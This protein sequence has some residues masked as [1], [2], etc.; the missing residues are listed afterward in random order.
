MDTR[1]FSKFE[2]TIAWR[3]LRA[4]RKEGGIS[5][6]AWYALIGVMLGVAALIVVQAVMIGFRE[7]FTD[8]ILGVNAHI[9]VYSADYDL[10]NNRSRSIEN[11]EEMA[12]AVAGVQGVTRAAPIIK[13]QV[14][15]SA[16]GQNSGVQIF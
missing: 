12:A 8:R 6:I 3:Y 10:A 2:W 4:R 1:P 13:A 15:A 7:E 5:V 9:T 11:F 14:M 16:N